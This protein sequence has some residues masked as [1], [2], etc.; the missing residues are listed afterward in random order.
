MVSD[1][2]SLHASGPD[3][4]FN[5]SIKKL[6]VLLLKYNLVTCLDE[7][8]F[9]LFHPQYVSLY[10]TQRSTTS[11]QENQ[12]P[13]F[14][15]QSSLNYSWIVKMML[16]FFSFGCP[17]YWSITATEIYH[18]FLTTSKIFSISTGVYV[19]ISHDIG[20]HVFVGLEITVPKDKVF[21]PKCVFFNYICIICI[22]TNITQ[23]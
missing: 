5:N 14:L 8:K 15:L 4:Y 3:Y 17:V 20:V 1:Q 22:K 16:F 7:I 10:E 19:F 13:L 11:L 12:F 23:I 18:L 21:F 6:I 9:L 2:W